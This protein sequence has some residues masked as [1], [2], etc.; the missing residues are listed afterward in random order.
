MD[1]N[2]RLEVEARKYRN[3]L[4]HSRYYRTNWYGA[5]SQRWRPE[6]TEINWNIPGTTGLIG[7]VHTARG[8]GQK[9]QKSTGTFQ[10][11]QD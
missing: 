5:Y 7:M 4:E 9:V 2:E 10:V 6:S 11:L 8:G 3:Q 1:E